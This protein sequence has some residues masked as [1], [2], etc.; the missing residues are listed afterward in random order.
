MN[1]FQPFAG[2]GD[3]AIDAFPLSVQVFTYLKNR[4]TVP[5]L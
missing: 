2:D 1:S 5:A 3:A 4:F